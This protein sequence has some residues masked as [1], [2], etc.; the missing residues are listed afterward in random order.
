[1][2]GLVAIETFSHTEDDSVRPSRTP[3][4]PTEEVSVQVLFQV[5][6]TQAPFQMCVAS[7][8]ESQ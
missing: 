5:M 7:H 3:D 2:P 8:N 1:M 6:L 4:G